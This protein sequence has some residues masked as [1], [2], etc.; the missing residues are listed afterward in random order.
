[1]STETPVSVVS[2]RGID[3]ADWREEFLR[4]CGA[5]FDRMVS[6]DGRLF[7][8]SLWEIEKAADEEMRGMGRGLVEMRLRADPLACG[9]R[10]FVC[11]KCQ[12]RMRVQDPKS[13]R[14]LR[15]SFGEVAMERPYCVCDHCEHACA[16]LDYALGI[17]SRGPSCTRRELVANAAT[18]DGSFE[19][20]QYT[21]AHHSKIAMSAEA[22]RK[23]AEGEGRNGVEENRRRVE[24]CFRKTKIRPTR[25]DRLPP[26]PATTAPALPSARRQT[27]QP[28]RRTH[29]PRLSANSSRRPRFSSVNTSVFSRECEIT[30]AAI[31]RMCIRIVCGLFPS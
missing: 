30:R 24:E 28:D 12:R 16:P 23:L 6:A 7:G 21:L 9:E 26:G 10:V 25:A 3:R 1:M 14:T 5:A 11:P 19:K 18:K 20:A 8:K 13:E 22:V 31:A 29:N 15:T 4:R 2:E 17:P 27:P